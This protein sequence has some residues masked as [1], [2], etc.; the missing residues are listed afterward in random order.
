MFFEHYHSIRG[1]LA[2][3]AV[4][5]PF[6]STADADTQAL[7]SGEVRSIFLTSPKLGSEVKRGEEFA[8]TWTSKNIGHDDAILMKGNQEV[9]KLS[10][11]NM[12]NRGSANVKIPNEIAPSPDKNEFMYY[13]G[14]NDGLKTVKDRRLIVIK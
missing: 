14:I 10:Q 13:I 9:G 1:G 4:L 12:A 2:S 7:K 8:V 5:L 6:A 11:P 3:L